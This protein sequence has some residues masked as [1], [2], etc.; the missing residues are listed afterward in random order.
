VTVFKMYPTV[1]TA[2]V[3]LYLDTRAHYLRIGFKYFFI[4]L[5]IYIFC[6]SWVCSKYNNIII[7][8]V[9]TRVQISIMIIP[10]VVCGED[11]GGS[12]E[13]A[14]NGQLQKVRI[15]GVRNDTCMSFQVA[16]LHSTFMAELIKRKKR[17]GL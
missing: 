3:I 15:Y 12:G 17:M 2:I 6:V 16:L 4:F 11:P 10:D 7:L 8:W 9:H 1:V 14:R 13:V 5:F